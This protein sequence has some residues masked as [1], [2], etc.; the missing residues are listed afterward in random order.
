M[1]PDNRETEGRTAVIWLTLLHAGAVLPR[2]E[3]VHRRLSRFTVEPQLE[4]LDK[5]PLQH[6][7]ALG[8]RGYTRTLR[9][10]H[11]IVPVMASPAWP[12]RNQIG[13]Q[14]GSHADVSPRILDQLF[15]RQ[16]SDTDQAVVERH[17]NRSESE[18][19]IGRFD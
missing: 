19:W 16:T 10:G 11:D 18:G 2:D 7:P 14:A 17:L 12:T 1:K 6:L 4:P 15:E 5:Q 3:R 9:P 13:M 8:P